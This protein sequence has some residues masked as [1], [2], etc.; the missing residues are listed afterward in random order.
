MADPAIYV[1]ERSNTNESL[2]ISLNQYTRKPEEKFKRTYMESSLRDYIKG[3]QNK[4]NY[5]L[6]QEKLKIIEGWPFIYWISD[7]FRNKFAESSLSIFFDVCSGLTTGNNLRFLR[8]WWEQNGISDNW[9]P[10]VKGGPYN[11]WY[12]NLWLDILWEENNR[13]IEKYSGSVIRNKQFYFREGLTFSG[14]STKGTSIRYMPEGMIF[15][16]M[17]AGIF[18]KKDDISLFYCLGFLNSLL[19]KY[20]IS[21]LNPTV[22]TEVGDIKKIPFVK[23]NSDLER[24]I[25]V[26]S[27]RSIEIKKNMCKYSIVEFNYEKSPLQL[28]DKSAAESLKIFFKSENAL[29]TELLLNEALIDKKIFKIYE[30]TDE[31]KQMVL[32]K[33]GISSGNLPL[34]IRE[35]MTLNQLKGMISPP[36]DT[37]EVIEEFVNRLETQQVGTDVW[38]TLKHKV[39]ELYEK[40]ESIEGI[41]LECKVNP[42]TVAYILKDSSVIPKN[43]SQRIGQEFVLDQIRSILMDDDDGI[44]PLHLMSGESTVCDRLVGKLH[45]SGFSQ[46]D[47]HFL[48]IIL[49]KKLDKYIESNFFAD[50]CDIL[51]K[52]MYLP[53]T[54]FIWH[55]SSGAAG[56]IDL[57]AIIYKWSRDKL[58]K[59]KSVYAQKRKTGL[60]NRLAQLSDGDSIKVDKEKEVIL[61]QLVEIDEFCK[62]IDKILSE[63]YDP[64][65]DDG[66]GKNIAPLQREGMLNIDVLTKKELTKFLNADW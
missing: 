61:E 14:S 31:D 17:G 62:K 16:N 46:K 32:T 56:G 60:E 50:E 40:G 9:K 59:V 8:Y 5:I 13:S 49:N 30:L 7:R 33:E 51:N 41:S 12:G 22:N 48:E 58:L 25:E 15:E 47:I 20:I 24:I 64:V 43:K 37:K 26:I 39:E 18:K 42:L 1:I 4:H 57:F 23:P 34:I 44:A 21:C 3:D 28:I 52:F 11:K 63:G 66:V 38:G 55:L 29:N 2:F 54:P 53:K 19:S 6:N 45:E 35:D 65:L 27:L 36:Q 10:F